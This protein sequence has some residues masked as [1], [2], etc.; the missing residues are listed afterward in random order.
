MVIC[1]E[2]KQKFLECSE[3][4]VRSYRCWNRPL[5]RIPFGWS[6]NQ[7]LQ[8]YTSPHPPKKKLVCPCSV[9][10]ILIFHSASITN[11]LI[12]MSKAFL[13]TNTIDFW[14]IPFRLLP[15][16]G[17][18][19]WSGKITQWKPVSDDLTPLASHPTLTGSTK[20][21]WLSLPWTYLPPLP[22][23][24]IHCG[25]PLPRRYSRQ[26]L[27]APGYLYGSPLTPVDQ[28]RAE[29]CVKKVWYHGRKA[30]S[31]VGASLERM[32]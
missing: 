14:R 7:T 13:L 1:L 8:S 23:K 10:R 6:V 32:G 18:H 11:I 26:V 24:L 21:R 30:P 3:M 19:K 25:S 22:S 31:V 9:C 28:E 16:K 20:L 27:S 4:F 29:E 2:K 5:R 12:H 15:R 17:T